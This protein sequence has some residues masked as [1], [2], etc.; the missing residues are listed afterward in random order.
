MPVSIASLPKNVPTS[1]G[2]KRYGEIPKYVPY[3]YAALLGDPWLGVLWSTIT[4]PPSPLDWS[5]QRL[6]TSDL[7]CVPLS[8]VPPQ[9]WPGTWGTVATLVY[10]PMTRR[11]LRRSAPVVG[12][13][14]PF[15]FSQS[16]VSR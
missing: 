6:L 14:S 16:T 10:W 1:D 5:N 15:R 11:V 7:R 4:W 8:W 12:L 3:T 9:Y 13:M 2:S